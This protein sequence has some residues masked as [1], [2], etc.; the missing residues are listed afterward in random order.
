MKVISYSLFGFNEKRKENCFVFSDYLRGLHVNI[1]LAKILYKDWA[2]FVHVDKNTYEGLSHILN[3]LPIKI[4]VCEDAPLTKAMLWRLK[5][6][7]EKDVTH[8]L[9]RDLDSPLTMR[10]RKCV[11]YWLRATKDCHAITDSVSHNIPLMGGMIGFRTEYFTHVTGWDSWENMVARDMNWESKGTDQDFL[12]KFV[13]PKFA[14]HGNDRITQHYM[15]GMPRSFLSDYHNTVP[16][17]ETGVESEFENTNDLCG[18]IGAS[19]A[20][21][22]PL[23]AFLQKYYDMFPELNEIEKEYKDIYYWQNEKI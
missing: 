14:K 16:E 3:R 11:E 9:S 20:Y 4:I 18:H 1:R 12:T 21:S 8:V 5:P 17:I 19:G 6:I 7:F 2:I 15:L 23:G 13:Y 10:E 22:T